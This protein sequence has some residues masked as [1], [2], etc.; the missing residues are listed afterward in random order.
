[1]KLTPTLLALAFSLFTGVSFAQTPLFTLVKPESKS[2]LDTNANWLTGGTNTTINITF[3][4]TTQGSLTSGLKDVLNNAGLPVPWINARTQN[5]EINPQRDSQIVVLVNPVGNSNVKRTQVVAR[6]VSTA[7]ALHGHPGI[8]VIIGGIKY[9]PVRP[10][11]LGVTGE[12]VDIYFM[13]AA[14]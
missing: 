6:Y 7:L 4:S 2:L 9:G 14:K 12:I 1:M 11:P 3:G 10:D 5:F 13:T 8:R